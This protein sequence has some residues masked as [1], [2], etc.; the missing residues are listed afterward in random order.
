MYGASS[1]NVF[2]IFLVH[3][4]CNITFLLQSAHQISSRLLSSSPNFV[5][6]FLDHIP[7]PRHTRLDISLVALVAAEPQIPT[8]LAHPAKSFVFTN[9]VGMP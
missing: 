5:F 1:N 6:D 4:V 7:I 3:H 2:E 9:L 8:F